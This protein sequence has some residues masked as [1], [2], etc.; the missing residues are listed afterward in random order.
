M[1]VGITLGYRTFFCPNTDL[2]LL[3]PIFFPKVFIIR[4]NYILQRLREGKYVYSMFERHAQGYDT[5]VNALA[6][7]GRD[8][9][10]TLAIF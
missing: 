4:S 1:A 5:M 10:L 8:L 9:G 7:S 2:G 3:E 6:F